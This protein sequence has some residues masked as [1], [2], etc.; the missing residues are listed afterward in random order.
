MGEKEIPEN[1][2]LLCRR[3]GSTVSTTVIEK[4]LP[5]QSRR[6]GPDIYSIKPRGQKRCVKF[7]SLK[8]SVKN[9]L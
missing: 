9:P 2:Y 3:P 8:P 6:L 4:R 5:Q 7:C 1:R